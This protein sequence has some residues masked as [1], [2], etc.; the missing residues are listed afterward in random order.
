MATQDL[1]QARPASPPATPARI[2]PLLEKLGWALI[3][4]IMIGWALVSVVNTGWVVMSSLKTNQE[5]FANVWAP[6]SVPQWANYANA[7]EKSHMNRYFLNSVLVS[8][9]S[10]VGTALFSAMASY[11]LARFNFRGN[12]FL[13]LLFIAGLA[14]PLQLIMVPIYLMFNRF[15]LLNS[16]PALTLMYVTIS[17]PFSIFV[18]TG[19]FRSLPRE[20]EEAAVLDGATEYQLFWQVMLPLAQP[21]LYTVSIFNFLGIWNEYL[22]AIFLLNDPAKMTVPVGIYNLRNVQGASGDWGSMIAGLIIILVPTFI[23]YLIFQN[24]IIG[25]LTAGALKG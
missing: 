1:V 9:A 3:Y 17:L 13:L 15:H 11:V 6:P 10:V 14:L 7:W 12:R 2:E 19:F 24:R 8:G 23:F 18:L 4:A 16:L 5:L 25:G 21:G 22:F 20:L